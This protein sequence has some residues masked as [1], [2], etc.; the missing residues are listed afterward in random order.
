M[1]IVNFIQNLKE[2]EKSENLFEKY[3]NVFDNHKTNLESFQSDFIMLHDIL[4]N[5]KNNDNLLNFVKC[6]TSS[7]SNICI[8]QNNKEIISLRKLYMELF[9]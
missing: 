3:Q 6:I 2:I 5:I 1:S 9:D 4:K 8:I 7:E